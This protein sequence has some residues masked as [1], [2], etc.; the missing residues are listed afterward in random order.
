M[1]V[2]EKQGGELIEVEEEGET[3]DNMFKPPDDTQ[4]AT[5]EVVD[6]QNGMISELKT[7]PVEYSEN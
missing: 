3:D 4:K 7:E 2:A 6:G 5:N 1:E